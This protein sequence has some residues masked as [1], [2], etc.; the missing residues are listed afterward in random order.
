MKKQLGLALAAG[1]ATSAVLVGTGGSASAAI[2][3]GSLYLSTSAAHTAADYTWAFVT[4][5]ADTVNGTTPITLTVPTDATGTPALS[6]VYGLGSCSIAST[7][8][9]AGTL[10]LTPTASCSVAS[11]TS[12][13][14]TVSGLTNG[15]AVT[16]FTSTVTVG[17]ESGPATAATT[18]G[19]TTVEVFVPE[20]VTFSDDTTDIKLATIPG[21]PVSSAAALTLTVGTNAVDGYSLTGCMDADLTYTGSTN[22]STIPGTSSAATTDLSS[23]AGFGAAAASTSPNV[24]LTTPWSTTTPAGTTVAGYAD[25]ATPGAGEIATGATA[26]STDTIKVTNMV[27]V[28]SDQ[29]AGEYDGTIH[30]AV[31]PNF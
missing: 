24:T 14:I 20:S 9:N 23:N 2:G 26:T 17:G 6:A 13:A 21:G 15:A 1:L 22:S 27:S 28:A 31:A 29:E 3:N 11:G 18:L 25:C 8:L 12:I 4:G 19:S 16:S 7:T 10:T 30:Y 5:S